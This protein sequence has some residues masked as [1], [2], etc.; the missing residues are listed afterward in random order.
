MAL[1]DA[2]ESE[3]LLTAEEAGAKL[4]KTSGAVL[5]YFKRGVKAPD[6]L[7][8]RLESIKLGG[9]LQ[10]S[11]EALQRW[12]ER[13]SYQ[14]DYVPPPSKREVSRRAK[15]ARR[16]IEAMYKGSRRVR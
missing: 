13:I 14:A 11:T 5:N 7:W 16:N 9:R 3:H 4:G 12:I 8:V 1:I 2:W 10:T 6:G 15:N